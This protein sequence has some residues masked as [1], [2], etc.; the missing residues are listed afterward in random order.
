MTARP[1]SSEQQ[2]SDAR[3]QPLQA[4]L[5]QDE[6]ES[7]ALN[8]RFLWRKVAIR[9]DGSVQRV[10]AKVVCRCLYTRQIRAQTRQIEKGA[11]AEDPL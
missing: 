10:T 3:K 4:L 9:G 7:V 2:G 5:V 6:T 1:I 11:E 8:E